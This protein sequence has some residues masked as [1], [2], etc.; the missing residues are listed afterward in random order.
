MATPPRRHPRLWARPR[1]S[2]MAVINSAMFSIRHTALY[3]TALVIVV[4]YR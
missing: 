1:I 4:F 3:L 2:R